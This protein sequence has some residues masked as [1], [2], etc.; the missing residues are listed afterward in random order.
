MSFFFTYPRAHQC[1]VANAAYKEWD[2]PKLLTAS[3]LM[4]NTASLQL[5][6]HLI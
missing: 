5:S 2:G 3:E 4:H 1:H 6:G